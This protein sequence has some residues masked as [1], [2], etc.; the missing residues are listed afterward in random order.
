MSSFP[1][2]RIEHRS[3]V[4]NGN[5]HD[6]P[7]KRG[8]DQLIEPLDP[9]HLKSESAEQEAFDKLLLAKLSEKRNQLDKIRK[10]RKRELARLRRERPMPR[11][12]VIFD[13]T[14]YTSMHDLKQVFSGSSRYI[15]QEVGKRVPQAKYS[16][17]KKWYLGIRLIPLTGYD[18]AAYEAEAKARLEA[19]Q[20]AAK[21]P[22]D[23]SSSDSSSGESSEDGSANSDET[24]VPAIDQ[25]NGNGVINEEMVDAL[26]SRYLIHAVGSGDRKAVPAK[27]TKRQK[28]PSK[29]PI[30]KERSPSPPTK[31]LRRPKRQAREAASQKL[32]QSSSSESVIDDS[33]VDADFDRAEIDNAE[34]GSEMKSKS[35]VRKSR[36]LTYKK[37]TSELPTPTVPQLLASITP[38]SNSDRT[39]VNSSL[40]H[41]EQ[42][43]EVT[44]PKPTTSTKSNNKSKK[45][46]RYTLSKGP[47]SELASTGR[48]RKPNRRVG[49][50][51]KLQSDFGTSVVSPNMGTPASLTASLASRN[52]T[53]TPKEESDRSEDEDEDSLQTMADLPQGARVRRKPQLPVNGEVN[54]SLTNGHTQFARRESNNESR[55][56]GNMNDDPEKA[57]GSQTV[58][59]ER[60]RS[61]EAIEDKRK[62]RRPSLMTT[63]DIRTAV[64]V[65][66]KPKK[67]RK[68]RTKKVLDPV[69]SLDA[70]RGP[71]RELVYEEGAVTTLAKVRDNFFP[72]RQTQMISKSMQ[73]RIPGCVYN[74]GK[75]HFLNVSIVQVDPDPEGDEN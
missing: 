49:L 44:P 46:R 64:P 3:V 73:L 55:D 47:M 23:E 20:A 53:L 41:T 58:A 31:R 18:K 61:R 27:K 21:T 57:N 5:S 12:S 6:R 40:Q 56:G 45:G 54:S 32:K 52:L 7:Q 17:K 16:T 11:K 51:G 69:E 15:V 22:S 74:R 19:R 2:P 14:T 4:E 71:K 38:S 29:T 66:D 65:E 62:S 9:K 26:Q 42:P 8:L 36:P 1:P 43:S 75:Q 33:D 68:P 25:S 34:S 10:D 50:A 24:P 37:R 28:L 72:G 67:E 13:P 59:E 60:Q 63:A 39:S 70:P 30:K 48:L 35:T